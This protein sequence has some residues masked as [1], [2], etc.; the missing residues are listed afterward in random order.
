M[1]EV[2]KLSRVFKV[3]ATPCPDPAPSMAPEDAVKLLQGTYPHLVHCTLEGPEV[4]GDQLVYTV[5]RPPAQTKGARERRYDVSLAVAVTGTS[6]ADAADAAADAIASARRPTYQVR[7]A[8]GTKRVFH[9]DLHTQSVT[10]TTQAD[11][12]ARLEATLRQ[13]TLC[14]QRKGGGFILQ[15]QVAKAV[16]AARAVGFQ[17][18]SAPR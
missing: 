1:S 15:G 9:V 17:I 7:E 12:V 10:D 3:G 16:S 6:P 8:G 5:V 13:M 14:I 4:V 2:Q 11:R 18:P